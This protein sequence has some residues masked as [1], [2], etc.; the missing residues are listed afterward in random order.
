[1]DMIDLDV[2][3]DDLNSRHGAQDLRKQLLEICGK[4]RIQVKRSL[5]CECH[6][7]ARGG[8]LDGAIQERL[9]EIKKKI[10]SL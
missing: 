5:N 4:A 10:D 1:M 2:H 9:K 7:L 3:R 6:G 8:L